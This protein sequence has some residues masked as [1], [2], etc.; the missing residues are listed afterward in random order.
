MKSQDILL[1]LKLVSLHRLEKKEL[2]S[3][4]I[5]E[6]WS[7]QYP[8]GWEGWEEDGESIIKTASTLSLCAEDRYSLRNL[9]A[10]TGISKTEIGASLNRSKSVNLISLD[11]HSGLPRVN[12]KGL[13]EFI[14]HGIKYV[15]PV[16]I[17]PLIRGIPTT[18][19]A[20]VMA[21]H[22]LSAGDSIFV[23]PDANGRAKG[24]SITPLYKTAP[25]AVKQDAYLYE[26]LALVDS[27]R[28]GAPR[29]SKL[30]SELFIQ[31]IE[32]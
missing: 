12:K 4:S 20:P 15:F 8:L 26:L 14:L 19:A 3:I 16:Q 5:A 30:A 22:L 21:E 25:K 24:Q 18:F 2:I 6:V 9:E 27:I 11:R 31:R 32:K 10:V 7:E 23:W 17:G 29:E 28:M 13:A 1:L